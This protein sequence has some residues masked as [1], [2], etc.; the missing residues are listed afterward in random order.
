[1]YTLLAP[2]IVQNLRKTLRANRELQ[3]CATFGLKM[4][5]FPQTSIF[6]EKSLILFSST[7]WPISLCQILKFF[8]NR[9]QGY[10]DGLFLDP[11]WVNFPKRTFF[12][13]PVD[14]PS[15]YHSSLSVCPKLKSDM[16][17]F[18]KYWRLKNIETSFAHSQFWP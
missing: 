11:K 1:M 2:F 4:V 10:E 18:M 8:Y 13:K 5:D 6:W 3:T 14:K 9:T 17:L 15:L 12:R 16:N 7:Y